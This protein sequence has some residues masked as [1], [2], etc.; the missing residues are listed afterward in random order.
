MA[1]KPPANTI[2]IGKM[3]PA[4]IQNRM[5]IVAFT[6]PAHSAS[7]AIQ[8][9]HTSATESAQ[10]IAIMNATPR[11]EFNHHPVTI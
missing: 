10:S 9:S 7:G 1:L 5:T 3:F 11:P 4:P 8:S 6:I 2:T